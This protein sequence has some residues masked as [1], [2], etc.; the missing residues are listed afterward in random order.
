MALINGNSFW[1]MNIFRRGNDRY[2]QT[3]GMYQNFLNLFNKSE[4]W[5]S[6]DGKESE[7]LKTTPQLNAVIYRRAEMVANGIWKHYNAKGEE[8]EN[9][10][11]VKLLNRPNPLQSR[12]EWIIQNDIQKSVYGNSL[13]YLLRGSSLA[14]PSALWNLSPQYVTIDRTGLLFNQTDLKNIVT[15]YKLKYDGTTGKSQMEMEPHEVMHRN[16]QDIDDPLLGTSPFHALK[17]PISNIRAAYGFRNVI[18]TEK[19]ALGI[20][21]N[22]SKNSSGAI[23][24]SA[25]ERKRIDKEYTRN[26]GI[27]DKQRKIIMSNASLVWQPMSYP[28]KEMMLFEEVTD[29]FRIIIDKYGMDEALFAVGGVGNTGTT[30]ENK[31]MAEKRVYEDTIIP[32]GEDLANSLTYKLGLEDKGERLELNYSHLAILQEDMVSKTQVQK[33]KAETAKTMKESDGLWTDDEIK[34]VVGLLPSE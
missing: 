16:I 14:L 21:S 7:L 29:D 34:E 20:L 3:P 27:S 17:M 31:N 1:N 25:D 18:I 30:F 28:T 5:V 23:P 6:I 19:G 2:T 26:Y 13:T 32:E 12:K 24:L 9:S 4:Q 11:V 22:N 8:V 33:N 10:D 15:K